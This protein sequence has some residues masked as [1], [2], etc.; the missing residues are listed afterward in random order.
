MAEWHESL[1]DEYRGNETLANIP[2]IDTLAKSYLDAQSYVGNSIRI[3][4]GDAGEEDW[5]KFNAKLQDKVPTLI[6][7]PADEQEA[8]AALYARLGR[9]EDAQGYTSEGLD[10]GFRDWAF[11]NGFTDSQIKALIERNGSDLEAATTANEEA[12]RQAFDGLKQEWGHA[13]DQ[14]LAAANKALEVYADEQAIEF[15]TSQGLHEN[16]DMIKMLAAI[17]KQL[18]EEP[19]SK[20]GNQGNSFALTPDEAKAQIAEIQNNKSHPYHTGKMDA[21]ERMNKLF[22]QAYPE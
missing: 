3:P 14:N 16:A 2:D 1:S 11:E 15:I 13:Y 17:G 21:V 4:S 10:E 7:I 18:G 5:S 12:A 19:A 20:I 22:E 9:P 8:K 6:N